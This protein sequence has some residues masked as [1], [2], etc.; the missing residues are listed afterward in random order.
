MTPAG[1]FNELDV[2]N[3]WE[4][5]TH[6]GCSYLKIYLVYAVAD[7]IQ[8]SDADKEQLSFLVF[9]GSLLLPGRL[10]AHSWEIESKRG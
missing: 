5:N 10:V 9:Y 7:R 3:E 6:T 8:K 1:T 4:E 2:Q